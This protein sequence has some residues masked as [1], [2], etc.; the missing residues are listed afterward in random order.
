MN[1]VLDFCGTR[2]LRNEVFL[3]A[4]QRSLHRSIFGTRT[5]NALDNLEV[6]D[7]SANEDRRQ[8]R[9]REHPENSARD[10]EAEQTEN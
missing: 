1:L 3:R 10:L 8:L 5:L 6:S 2:L 9:A 4:T 7:E